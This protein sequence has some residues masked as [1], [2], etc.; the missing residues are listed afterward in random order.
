MAPPA[1]ARGAPGRRARALECGGRSL[2][3]R[4]LGL[5]NRGFLERSASAAG[6]S[7]GRPSCC[8]ESEIHYARAHPH[9]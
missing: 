5:S 2:P 3:P 1:R 7:S 9:T 6:A 8:V 4:V